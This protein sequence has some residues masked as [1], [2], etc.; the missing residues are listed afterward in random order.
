[1][2]YLSYDGGHRVNGMLPPIHD[3][4]SNGKAV[5]VVQIHEKSL[6]LLGPSINTSVSSNVILVQ[7]FINVIL[8][9]GFL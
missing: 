2:M 9:V 3:P 4:I 7:C 5:T 1:M 6:M 8:R